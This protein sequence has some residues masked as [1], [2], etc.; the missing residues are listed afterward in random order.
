[1]RFYYT[2]VKDPPYVIKFLCGFLLRIKDA[3]MQNCD[4][5]MKSIIVKP[6]STKTYIKET[7]PED[8]VFPGYTV[9]ETPDEDF[10]CIMRKI[11][12]YAITKRIPS[13]NKF[14]FRLGN[15]CELFSNF[16]HRTYMANLTRQR[17]GTECLTNFIDS[18]VNEAEKECHST[19]EECGIE[20][21]TK[22][23]P[24]CQTIGWIKY[25]CE[26]CAKKTGYGYI[27]NNKIFD[28]DGVFVKNTSNNTGS[29]DCDKI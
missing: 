12:N 7:G 10:K 25:I 28:K 4:F 26:Q 23:S 21:G 2:I 19:C 20:I 13:R 6:A 14:I 24:R 18:F 9:I 22:Y 5:K 16:M 17:V 11:H 15:A 27:K 29:E 1:L 3:I 8:D